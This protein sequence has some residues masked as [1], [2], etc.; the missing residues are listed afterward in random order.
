MGTVHQANHNQIRD[1]FFAENIKSGG[2]ATPVAGRKSS[3]QGRK[4]KREGRKI[5]GEGRNIAARIL[6]RV[7]GR[8]QSLLAKEKEMYSGIHN[9]LLFL[10]LLSKKPLLSERQFLR[11]FFRFLY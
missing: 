8:L 5:C 11:I 3:R 7:C 10:D 6:E 2:T 9:L 1:V 4:V